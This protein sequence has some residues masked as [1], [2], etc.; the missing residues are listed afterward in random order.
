MTGL[1]R[2]RSGAFFGGRDP[3]PALRPAISEALAIS[4]VDTFGLPKLKAMIERAQAADSSHG[5]IEGGKYFVKKGVRLVVEEA[6]KAGVG[7]GAQ[8]LGKLAQ[9]LNVNAPFATEAVNKI[10]QKAIETPTSFVGGKIGDKVSETGY[11]AGTDWN[12]GPVAA[13]VD[14][15]IEKFRDAAIAQVPELR[16][17][18]LAV[19]EAFR[20]APVAAHDHQDRTTHGELTKEVAH[21]IDMLCRS[22]NDLNAAMSSNVNSLS[23]RIRT[24]C[25]DATLVASALYFFRRKY[26]KLKMFCERL[27]DDYVATGG[28]FTQAGRLWDSV[29]PRLMADALYMLTWKGILENGIRVPA[30]PEN[31]EA[32]KAAALKVALRDFRMPSETKNYRA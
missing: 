27:M 14:A 26:N 6:F 1:G 11:R 5:T 32:L 22:W 9:P 12:Y 25:G 8:A 4:Y 15:D 18:H 13:S 31:L 30:D 2:R 17:A 20:S 21:Q 24:N 28:A 3:A 16:L 23:A 10:P 7:V 19:P 29:G